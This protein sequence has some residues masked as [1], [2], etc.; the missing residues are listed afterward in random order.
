MN[1]NKNYLFLL[2]FFIVVFALTKDLNPFAAV[3]FEG[4]DATQ[5]SR[6]SDFV[7]SLRQ[8]M[9]PP[10]IAQHFS[11][12]LGYPLFNFYAPAAYWI[13]SLFHLMGFSI[14]SALKISYAAATAGA[15]IFMF[16]FLKKHFNEYA[17]LLGSTVYVTIP[18]FAV[19]IFVRA[20]LAE[21]W[22]LCLFPLGLYLITDISQKKFIL[23]VIGL[24][25]LF[26][27]HNVLSLVTVPLLVVYSLLFAQDKKKNILVIGLSLL[28]ASYFLVPAVVELN[29]VHA[30]S[31]AS[32]TSYGD[33]FLCFT[34]LWDSP[35]GNGGSVPGC[36]ADG[37]SFKQGKIQILLAVLGL[38][39]LI[40]SLVRSKTVKNNGVPLFSA[41][42]LIISTLLTTYQ[43]QFIW[44]AGESVLS[45]FQFPWRLLVFVMFGIGFFSAYGINSLRNK[46]I[47]MIASLLMIAGLLIVN[48][49]YFRKEALPQA[50]FEKKYLSQDYIRNKVAYAVPEYLPK[51]ADFEY[52]KK[53]ETIGLVD[54][55]LD[56]ALI[57]P[58]HYYP[59]WEIRID[60]KKIIPTKFDELGRPLVPH[61]SKTADVEVKYKQTPIQVA[62]NSISLLA[63]ILLPVFY[64]RLWKKTEAK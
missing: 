57:V 55:Q 16:L 49:K 36:V 52:W 58:I 21:I 1:I 10:R 15:F 7:Y 59:G 33:H 20:N 4:H 39:S 8:G 64:R 53:I 18:Y 46:R 61:P 29:L 13:T 37:M 19:E 25:L 43:S 22:F 6:I 38:V 34:Q 14:I 9:I 35:W 31:V 26:T 41:A 45:L 63:F 50:E 3:M 12:G 54:T 42:L 23:A 11:Y 2:I 32:K 56:N 5:A 40:F 48:I 27:V 44:K 62:G 60:G 24:S 51:S 28:M 17:S 30:T 47:I